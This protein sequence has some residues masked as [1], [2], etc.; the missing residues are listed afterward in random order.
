MASLCRHH[1]LQPA[2]KHAA[3]ILHDSSVHFLYCVL[4]SPLQRLTGV[5]RVLVGYLL[6]FAPDKIVVGVEV[7]GVRRPELLGPS[8]AH[9]L[10]APLL[11]PLCCIS[12]CRALLEYISSSSSDFLDPGL[13]NP[14]VASWVDFFLFCRVTSSCLPRPAPGA[15]AE[16]PVFSSFQNP[17]RAFYG[18]RSSLFD[19]RGHRH[20][21]AL[22]RASI[23]GI[24][25]SLGHSETRYLRRRPS[26]A[27]RQEHVGWTIVFSSAAR[28]DLTWPGISPISHLYT[29]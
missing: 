27:Q 23:W 12:E 29:L 14:Q 28:H 16:T 5:M 9:A 19:P 26:C 17:T 10:P 13:Q 24:P 3:R 7:W 4:S 8:R 1:P 22:A 15:V 2:P 6:N 11:R 20:P 25:C 18:Q 21:A